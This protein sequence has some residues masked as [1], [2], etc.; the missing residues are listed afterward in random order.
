ME[1]EVG[2]AEG[3]V[4]VAEGEVGVAEG[5]VG[6]AEGEVGVAEGEVAEGEV[7]VA[8]AVR[9]AVR[10]LFRLGVAVAEVPLSCLELS[11]SESVGTGE[12]R[13]E[14]DSTP[15]NGHTVSL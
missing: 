14:P 11:S 9:A 13:G 8:G 5:E 7:G 4:G 10:L 1:G 12:L 2:V 15:G 6:V 3:E